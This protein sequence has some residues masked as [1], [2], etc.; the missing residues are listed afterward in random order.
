LASELIRAAGSERAAISFINAAKEKG[1]AGRREGSL[2]YRQIDQQLLLNVWS[3]RREL[4]RRR[5]PVPPPK[6]LLKKLIRACWIG[7]S[8]NS[9]RTGQWDKEVCGA[10]SLPERLGE[11]PQ[12]V[13]RRLGNGPS[14]P[15]VSKIPNQHLPLPNGEAPIACGAHWWSPY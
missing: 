10:L 3:L 2:A 15:G 14:C 11:D 9:P 5:R 7:R 6:R 1:Q 12:A 13:F 8:L 4:N